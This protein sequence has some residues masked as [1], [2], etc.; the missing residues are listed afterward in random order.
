MI[1]DILK[2]ADERMNKT[3]RA[4]RS[5]L[6]KIRT[7]RAHPSLLE[8]V[9]VDYYGSQ[10]PLNQAA[11]IN[12]LDAR[13][14]GVAPWDKNMVGVI[15]KAILNSDLGLNP[16]TTGSVMRVPLPALTEERRKE[17]TRVVRSE[18]E[19]ARVAIRN[20]RRDANHHLKEMLKEKMITE[21]EDRREEDKIQKMTDAHIRDIDQILK[22]KESEMMEI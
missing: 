8:H 2:D 19:K 12:V 20:I 15:E 13:T 11:N 14:L 17:L 1:E 6:S 21:D 3:L 9:S 22:D 16:V 10:V 5:E 4:L 18:V 7:G